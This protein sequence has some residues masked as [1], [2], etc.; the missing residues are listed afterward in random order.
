L[1]CLACDE[2][3]DSSAKRTPMRSKSPVK[4]EKKPS[5]KVVKG[6]LVDP[7]LAV[8]GALPGALAGILAGVLGT[9]VA[10]VF[11]EMY[12]GEI[13][14]LVFLGFALGLALG[15]FM[16]TLFRLLA[17]RLKADFRLKPGF[18]VLLGGALIGSA[19]S[20]ILVR[21]QWIPLGAGVGGMGAFLWVFL[22]SKIE[23]TLNPARPPSDDDDYFLNKP[24]ESNGRRSPKTA[25]DSLEHE[26]GFLDYHPKKVDDKKEWE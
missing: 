11:S 24:Q 9:L 23:P 4:T 26:N 1:K 3:L 17:R 2:N 18:S 25:R 19:V 14:A 6:P 20:A 8:E 7:N 22:S 10:G 15:A 21:H 12:V 16:G 13:V 5:P